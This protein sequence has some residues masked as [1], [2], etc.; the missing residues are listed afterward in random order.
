MSGCLTIVFNI[1][2]YGVV[3]ESRLLTYK[4]QGGPEMMDV[5]IGYFDTVDNDLACTWVI[6]AL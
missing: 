4:S 2:S 3:E 6:E 1:I 5:V